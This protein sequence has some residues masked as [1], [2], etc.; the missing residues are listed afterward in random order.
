MPHRRRAQIGKPDAAEAARILTQFRQSGIAGQ[1]YLE[2]ELH[3]LPRRGEEKVF[4]G[5]LWGG[6]NAEGAIFR[7]SVTDETGRDIR[8]L[9]QNG[10]H[11]A[12]WRMGPGGVVEVT[13][14]VFEPIVSG[15]QLAAFDLQMPFLY[16]P[17]ATVESIA[18]IRQRPAHEFIFR[19][20]EKFAAQHPELGS[21]RSYFDAQ[22]SAPVQTELLGRDGAVLKTLALVDLKKVGDQMLIKSLDVR[23]EVTRDKTRLLFTAAALNVDHAPNVFEPAALAVEIPRPPTARLVPLEP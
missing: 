1:Y 15:V 17:D 21:V 13:G 2:F 11:A 5:R 3:Q 19:P 20:P 9:V 10:A 7:I 4:H 6:R 23:D 8:L 16:W 22:F 18:R 14:P 12:V